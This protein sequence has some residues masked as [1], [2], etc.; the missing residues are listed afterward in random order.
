MQ[1][2]S[3]KHMIGTIGTVS[4]SLL[5]Y[6]LQSLNTFFSDCCQAVLVV[7]RILFKMETIKD[8][9]RF[10]NNP[11]HV[12][13]FQQFFGLRKVNFSL[14]KKL[15]SAMIMIKSYKKVFIR[16]HLY[17]NTTVHISH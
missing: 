8:M 15:C 2:R 9:F 6:R 7:K 14:L 11:H 3:E 5:K 16:V 10:L 4:W 17:L 1:T 13:K 12:W